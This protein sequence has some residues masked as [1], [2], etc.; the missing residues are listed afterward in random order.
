MIRKTFLLAF[1]FITVVN[2][3]SEE[4]YSSNLLG[5]ALEKIDVSEKTEYEYILIKSSENGIEQEKLFKD[6]ELIF[7]KMYEQN[8]DRTI[9]TKIEDE[10]EEIRTRSGGVVLSEL[11]RSPG[12]NEKTEYRYKNKR[13]AEKL[14]FSDEKLIYTDVYEY[15]Y[16]GRL[17][18]VKRNYTD[19]SA[20]I[21]ISFIFNDGRIGKYMLKNESNINYIVFNNYGILLDESYLEN[22]LNE[23]RRYGYNPDGS[24]SE[25]IEYNKKG[26]ILTFNYDS[27][28]RVVSS[29]LTDASEKLI[30]ESVYIYRNGRIKEIKVKSELYLKKYVYEYNEQDELISETLSR[31]GVVDKITEYV[32]PDNYTE[33]IYQ[34][35][36]K[37]IKIFY[38]EGIRTATE[39]VED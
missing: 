4:Y 28:G 22:D 15:T 21:K 18:D 24:R 31:N 34:Q 32:D 36:Q 11:T 35:G 26:Q 20:E 14:Y 17:L 33:T 10:I 13:L 3:Y 29:R 30:E 12:G 1:I 8:G 23:T 7:K 38:E 25:R 16:D 5:M 19:D 9:E 6:N 27:G 37:V 2:L 39:Q